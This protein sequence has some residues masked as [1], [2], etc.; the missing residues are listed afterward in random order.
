[1]HTR[2]PHNPAS[3][4]TLI[5][6]LVVMGIATVLIVATVPVLNVMGGDNAVSSGVNTV[7][8]SAEAARQLATTAAA[9]FDP[10]SDE[11]ASLGA[12]MMVTN[13]GEV[14][15]LVH[16]G[17]QAMAGGRVAFKDAAN[18][19]GSPRDYVSLG[20]RT[21]MVGIK[22]DGTGINGVRYVAPPFAIRFNEMGSMVVGNP[23]SAAGQAGLV[24][25]DKDYNGTFTNDSR[26]NGYNPDAPASKSW[27]STAGKFELLF[28]EIDTVIGVLVFDLNDVQ[29]IGL[30]A[31]AGGYISATGTVGSRLTEV[32][33]PVFFNRV[34][35]APIY[36]K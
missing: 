17:A 23:G 34:T 3:A 24:Y 18:T 16:N 4:F 22:R 28:D 26:P 31:D 8:V 25:Y 20:S 32:G 6:M 11:G 10:L 5:E 15:I 9:Q 12:A 1:M 30:V 14:R 29:E 33:T 27:N 7:A 35:G 19:A 21:G 13:T 2:T 36:R